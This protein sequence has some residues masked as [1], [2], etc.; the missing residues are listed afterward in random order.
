M[1]NIIS[2]VNGEI[3]H[4]I[5]YAK[6]ISKKRVDVIAENHHLQFS[7]LELIKNKKFRPH[8]HIPKKIDYTETT[9]QEAWVIIKG[10]IKVIHY[11]INSKILNEEILNA[12]DVAITLSGGHTFEVLE[13]DTI[14]YEFKTGPYL[15]VELDKKFIK[16]KSLTQEEYCLKNNID[17]YL[18]TK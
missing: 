17:P 13:E 10:S 8:F 11:D 1:K 4:T 6:N 18:Q 7:A 5:F 3:L 14:L 9:S 16:D 2:K 12:G 15:G